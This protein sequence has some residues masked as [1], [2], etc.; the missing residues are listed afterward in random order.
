[1]LPVQHNLRLSRPKKTLVAKKIYRSLKTKSALRIF[2]VKTVPIVAC[3]TEIALFLC[4]RHQVFKLG[5]ACYTKK[6]FVVVVRNSNFSKTLKYRT[7]TLKILLITYVWIKVFSKTV[8][9]SYN[10]NFCAQPHKL[11][12]VLIALSTW[13]FWVNNYFRS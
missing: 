9:H 5:R 13:D 1:M 12:I 8:F 11:S 2:S 10:A 3:F 6:I 7:M 4:D